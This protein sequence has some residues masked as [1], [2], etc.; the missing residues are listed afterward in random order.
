MSED[1]EKDNISLETNQRKSGKSNI[2]E[3]FIIRQN[4][5][6]LRRIRVTAD[7]Y[8]DENNEFLSTM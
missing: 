8:L 7:P 3:M 5:G 1:I 6:E 4:D 2:Y